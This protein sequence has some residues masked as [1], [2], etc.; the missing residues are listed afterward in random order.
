MLKKKENLEIRRIRKALRGIRIEMNKTN[1]L[2][3]LL[4]EFMNEK[5]VI[6]LAVTHDTGIETEQQGYM[7]ALK[8]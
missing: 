3:R 2:L 5:P 6:V 8:N 1:E 4:W 7:I